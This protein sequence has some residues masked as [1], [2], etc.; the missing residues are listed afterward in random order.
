[1]TGTPE[2]PLTVVPVQK[3]PTTR[4]F[5]LVFS[6]NLLC[7]HLSRLF[8]ILL[9]WTQTRFIIFSSK[10]SFY[11]SECHYH[12]SPLFS[13]SLN[14]LVK[15][16]NLHGQLMCSKLLTTSVSSILFLY[17]RAQNWTQGSSC[18]AELPHVPHRQHSQCLSQMFVL[19]AMPALNMVCD[20]H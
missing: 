11:I 16:F 8:L 2:A 14:E 3:W 13:S 6:C 4:K 17:Y 7:C 10:L 15:F 19:S 12:I 18:R 1:M 20:Q 9:T 5:H